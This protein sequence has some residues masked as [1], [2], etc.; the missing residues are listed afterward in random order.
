MKTLKF[1]ILTL[2]AGILIYF[3]LQTF[4]EDEMANEPFY[5]SIIEVEGGYGY[6]IY[7]ENRLLIQQES[8]PSYKGNIPFSSADDAKKV[9]DLVINKICKGLNPKITLEELNELDIVTLGD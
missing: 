8:V 5:C 1:I 4:V 9:A 3:I 7:V 2:T 6:H